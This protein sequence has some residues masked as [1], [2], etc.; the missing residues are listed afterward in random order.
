MQVQRRRATEYPLACDA[1][2]DPPLDLFLSKIGMYTDHQRSGEL[3][4]LEQPWHQQRHELTTRYQGAF[5]V[6]K[7]TEGL[8]NLV[9]D[10]GNPAPL[11]GCAGQVK[12]PATEGRIGHAVHVEQLLH[13]AWLDSLLT[14]LDT[15][16]LRPGPFALPGEFPPEQDDLLARGPLCDQ[17]RFD[18][19]LQGIVA[20]EAPRLFAVVQVLGERVD[21]R[22]AAWGMAFDG[23]VDVVDVEGRKHFNLRSPERA[24]MGFGRPNISAQVVWVA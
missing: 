9:A 14:V 21:G 19:L 20:D 16:Q 11:I 12:N 3:G 8:R 13:L 5:H 18:Q 7:C 23:R 6:K 2:R 15:R 1:H 22:V 17:D 10:S 4:C 24:A